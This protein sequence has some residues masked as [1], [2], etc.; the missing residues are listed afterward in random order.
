[1]LPQIKKQSHF[2]QFR[3]GKDLGCRTLVPGANKLKGIQRV[4]QGKTRRRLKLCHQG[5]VNKLTL[6][7]AMRCEQSAQKL[8]LAATL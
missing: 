4:S 1:M 7:G 2:N 8:P 3:T 6:R 5:H